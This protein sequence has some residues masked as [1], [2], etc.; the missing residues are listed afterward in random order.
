MKRLL[1]IAIAVLTIKAE[2]QNCTQPVSSDV[3]TNLKNQVQQQVSNVQALQRGREIARNNCF[4]A[5]QAKELLL[6]YFQDVHKTEIG[7]L[8]YANV[9]DKN[10]FSQ[11]YDYYTSAPAL[12]ALVRHVQDVDELQ[13]SNQPGLNPVVDRQQVVFPAFET[14]TGRR[15]TNQQPMTMAQ[16]A[17]FKNSIMHQNMY[18]QLQ[19]ALT[20]DRTR[21]FSLSQVMD[22]ALLFNEEN[23]RLSV[24]Q[25]YVPQT[26]D[27]DHYPFALQLLTTLANKNSY[28]QNVQY[29]IG[30][31][32]NNPR[33]GNNTG[34]LNPATDAEFAAIKSNLE[35]IRVSSTRTKQYRAIVKNKCLSVVQ[36][37]ALM[38]LFSAIDR[39]ELLKYS[40]DY[41]SDLQNYYTLSDVLSFSSEIEAFSA[42]LSGK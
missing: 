29:L 40:Y 5:A 37:R 11:V 21:F 9:A 35:R 39:L 42:F 22:I 6:L 17:Q 1:L 25:H 23:Q 24:L 41:C 2:A 32:N 4:S 13:Q 34:C 10:N 26:C 28:V 3:F 27:I 33:P 14:Y 7:K 12:A 20:P 15:I 16:F 36:I 31:S 8:I 38:Q 30:N 19:K 18:V